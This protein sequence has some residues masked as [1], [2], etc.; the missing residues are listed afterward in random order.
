MTQKRV[1]TITAIML[2]TLGAELFTKEEGVIN[3]KNTEYDTSKIY[4][5]VIDKIRV[6][7]NVKLD[8]NRY[9]LGTEDNSE[10]GI[11]RFVKRAF[12]SVRSFFTGEDGKQEVVEEIVHKPT[13]V[14]VLGDGTEVPNVQKL[15][16]IVKHAK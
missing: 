5:K 14:A 2:K 4:Q 7:K 13:T 16:N 6:G 12:Y 3:L 11:I 10:L 1:V 9:I 15:N 8:I